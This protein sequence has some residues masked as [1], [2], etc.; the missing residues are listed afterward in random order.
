MPILSSMNSQTPNQVVDLSSSFHLIPS[1]NYLLQNLKLFSFDPSTTRSTSLDYLVETNNYVD[2]ETTRYGTDQNTTIL[3]RMTNYEIEIP[4]FYRQD[5]ITPEAFQSRRRFGSSAELDANSVV[6]S[7]LEAH[8]IAYHAT[9]ERLLAKALFKNTVDATNTR[10]PNINWEDTFGSQQQVD[11][12]DLAS[13]STD[14]PE[15]LDSVMVKLRSAL[16]SLS[17]SQT[18]TLVFCGSS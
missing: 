15:F 13:A 6:I 12:V 9:R 7:Y 5:E 4:H 1:P 11:T 3:P 10:N 16:G 17:V 8:S 14:V 2:R 18:D